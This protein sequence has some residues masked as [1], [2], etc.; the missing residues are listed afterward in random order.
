MCCSRSCTRRH[1]ARRWAKP[2][3]SSHVYGLSTGSST[4]RGASRTP[5]SSPPVS[6]SA[7][8]SRRWPSAAPR[9]VSTST[10]W[11]TTSWLDSV[12]VSRR[13]L[14]PW[15][16]YSRPKGSRMMPPPR[17]QIYRRPRVTFVFNLL[18][19][20]VKN[21]MP[22]SRGS[23]VPICIEIRRFFRFQNIVFM[24]LVTDERSNKRTG[25]CL[26]LPVWPGGGI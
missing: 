11:A 14:S 16:C 17:F 8:W 4:G 10:G 19:H 21:F 7:R 26:R 13:C 6:P 5:A 24:H 22:V 9:E 2:T 23:L 1:T 25:Y 12:E 3:C 20:E 15:R 18:T